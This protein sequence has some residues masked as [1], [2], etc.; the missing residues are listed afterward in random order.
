MRK[1]PEDESGSGNQ[2]W[3]E[4]S[5]F[6]DK[7][8]LELN[9]KTKQICELYVVIDT[10]QCNLAAATSYLDEAQMAAVG[11]HS[12]KWCVGWKPGDEK[13]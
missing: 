10:L 4:D 7:L 13:N 3:P 9:K 11:N 1:T 6:G 8:K 12:F 5:I 2:P